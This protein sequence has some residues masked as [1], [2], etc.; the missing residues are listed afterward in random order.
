MCKPT[1]WP[2]ETAAQAAAA[3]YR[4]EERPYTVVDITRKAN[5][6]ATASQLLT[7]K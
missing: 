7:D 2:S 5:G 6:R 4:A 1:Y 3:A